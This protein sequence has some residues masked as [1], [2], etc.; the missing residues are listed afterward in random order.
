MFS[1]RPSTGA[2]GIVLAGI[3]TMTCHRPHNVFD[4]VPCDVVGS[5]ILATSAASVQVPPLF[6]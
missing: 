4:V 3:A 2:L 6:L 1:I 5:V